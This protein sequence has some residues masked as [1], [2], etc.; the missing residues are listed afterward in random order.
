MLGR[1]TL[2]TAVFLI[3]T[4]IVLTTLKS[5]SSIPTISTNYAEV[6]IY[7]GKNW[8]TKYY[9]IQEKTLAFTSMNSKII[10][11]RTDPSSYLQP[12]RVFIDGK[13]PEPYKGTGKLWNA[14]ILVLDGKTHNLLVYFEESQP[15]A[16]LIGIFAPLP[17]HEI[18]G[19]QEINVLELPGFKIAGIKLR[20]IL[21]EEKPL[22]SIL[23]A[24]FFVLN[25]S[26]VTIMGEKF[27]AYDL[28]SP[29]KN[30]TISPGYIHATYT[31]LY[32]SEA[33]KGSEIVLPP[34]DFRLAYVNYPSK[35]TFRS[36]MNQTNII[37]G[38]PPRP[39]LVSFTQGK[40]SFEFQRHR[41]EIFVSVKNACETGK[42]S[43]AFMLPPDTLKIRD[44][45]YDFGEN[46]TLTIRF[47][48]Q[49][50]AVLDYKV[51][52]PPSSLL[53]ESPFYGLEI[54]A[55][56]SSGIPIPRANYTLYSSGKI[57]KSGF[58]VNGTEYIC[59]LPE[60]EYYI[61][62]SI[63]D[64]V[65]GKTRHIL[66]STKTINLVTNTTTVTVKIL[67]KGVGEPLETF[68]VVLKNT[69]FSFKTNAK[70]GKAVLHGIPFGV[71]TVEIY[72]DGLKIYSRENVE[73][74][75]GES[76][77]K[78]VL[79]IY[80]TKVKVTGFFGQPVEGLEVKVESPM[81]TLKTVTNENGLADLGYLPAGEYTV[82]IES[83]GTLSFSLEHDTYKLVE[84]DIIGKYNGFYI[85]GSYMVFLVIV[86]VF[87]VFLMFLRRRK[88]RSSKKDGGVVEV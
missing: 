74:T 52:T 28:I 42:I 1:N 33:K 49:G 16:P 45:I 44:N 43:Y 88:K 79:P 31:P 53:V 34:Y 76:D 68:N 64:K 75:P 17:E 35:I 60:G 83:F 32:Y 61:V 10:I 15:K 3:F 54:K 24:D 20:I 86:V 38:N 4:L 66:D 39:L 11:I 21:S 2:C 36:G 7:D 56:D 47:Y 37:Y 63:G 8:Q 72:L 85:K 50:I 82:S 41:V 48:Y 30:I 18:E 22:Y 13:R 29:S 87:L 14:Y 9:Q 5:A 6:L 58:L 19:K 67:R 25:A 84:T 12:S 81:L 77:L 70:D 71:Y 46:T 23:S 26:K 57:V 55:V 65:I 73:I 62:L 80:K 27:V 59:P 78:F 40:V 51:Y 69:K